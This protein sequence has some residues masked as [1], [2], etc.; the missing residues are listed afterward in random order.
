M[1]CA[2]HLFEVRVTSW[3]DNEMSYVSQLVRTLKHMVELG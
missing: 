2:E 1:Q 3:Y